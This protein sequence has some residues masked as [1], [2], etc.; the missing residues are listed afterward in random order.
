MDVAAVQLNQ[1]GI[2]QEMMMINDLV[3]SIGENQDNVVAYTNEL[4]VKSTKCT[5]RCRHSECKM[6][7]KR[8]HN[9]NDKG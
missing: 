1:Q 2:S 5:A 8:R 7:C 9:Q 4:Q 3:N 6:G